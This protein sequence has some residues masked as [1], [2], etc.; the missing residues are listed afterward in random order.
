MVNGIGSMTGS[1]KDLPIYQQYY[2]MY[3]AYNK[4]RGTNISFDSWLQRSN[5][6]QFF[7]QQVEN[8]IE[9]GN[10]HGGDG[11]N[12]N[13]LNAAKYINNGNNSIYQSQDE[14]TYYDFDFDNGTYTVYNSNEQVATV[15]GLDNGGNIDAISFGY[16]TAEIVDYTF[17]NLSDGQDKYTSA[18]SGGKYGNVT[19]SQKEFDID[20]I[21]DAL[22]MN[23]ND[24]QYQ[25]AAEIFDE[26]VTNMNQWCSQEDLAELDSVAAR[27][28]TNSVEYKS[29]LKEIILNNLDQAGE[30]V[31][32][33]EH[34]KFTNDASVNLGVEGEDAENANNIPEY[35]KEIL[36]ENSGYSREY[37]EGK[38]EGGKH[39]SGDEKG[40]ALNDA[41]NHAEPLMA[42]II[43]QL[44]SQI[45]SNWTTEM[46]KYVI[47]IKNDLL[48]DKNYVT[49]HWDDEGW[50]NG[51]ARGIVHTQKLT[52]EFLRR[53]DEM[54]KNSGKTDEEVAKDK[55][56]KKA[57]YQSL[58][59]MD[60]NSVASK[61]GVKDTTVVPT[62]NNQ[63]AEIQNKA[64]NSVI[65]PLKTKIMEQMKGKNIPD[66]ELNELLDAAATA[67]LANP[68]DWASTS[69]SYTY[70]IDSD[71]LVD[72]YENFVKQGIQSKGYAF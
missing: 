65:T 16:K 42:T 57:D 21:M 9:T 41:K 43:S 67:A 23:P 59:N 4:E 22:L 27:Y 7:L 29:K 12:G 10:V 55:E 38:W 6:R 58:Y 70:T 3:L 34:V 37:H 1:I 33:H 52:D 31:E 63:Y 13:T 20:Y 17:G 19:Y 11:V 2:E 71:K 32:G 14:E 24:P 30:W 72:I 64:Y 35:D 48:F 25:I 45:G 51:W 39:Y 40:K 8:Y 28:G 69:N 66:S 50:G 68:Q 46:D 49:Y 18:V 56:A 62:G 53:F 47:R 60:L 54:C 15:L 61:A 5:Y 44:Q 36:I 26:L